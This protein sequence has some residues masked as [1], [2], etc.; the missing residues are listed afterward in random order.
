MDDLY[1]SGFVWNAGSGTALG[2][3][4]STGNGSIFYV[5]GYR[6]GDDLCAYGYGMSAVHWSV[7]MI[8]EPNIRC[9]S[10]LYVVDDRYP[11]TTPS[12]HSGGP[13]NGYSIRPIQDIPYQAP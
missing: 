11:L 10:V 4:E 7:N 12:S 8:W 13:C 5:T 3:R 6:D 9:R 2:Y 1:G